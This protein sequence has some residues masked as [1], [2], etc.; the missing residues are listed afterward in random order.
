VKDCSRCKSRAEL[1]PQF[2]DMAFELTPCATCK[3]WEPKD[4]KK[5]VQP[6]DWQWE[7]LLNG[8]D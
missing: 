2:K 6:K 3:P 7:D 5:I 8:E 1:N 4:E